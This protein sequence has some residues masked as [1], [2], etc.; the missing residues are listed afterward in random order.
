MEDENILKFIISGI[1]IST[2]NSIRRIMISQIP[3]IVIENV[4]IKEN[5]SSFCDNIIVHRLG[6]IPLKKNINIDNNIFEIKLTASGPRTVYSRDIIFPDNIKPVDGNI[7]IMKLQ[8]GEHIDLFG[9]TEEGIGINHSKFSVCCGTSYKK[10][11]DNSVE[12]YIETTGVYTAKEVFIKSLDI[13]KNEITQCK[14]ML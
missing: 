12:F 8:T 5:N 10:L 9:S 7:I 2:V 13:L 3:S 4:C 11:S 6:Q 14:K 1:D